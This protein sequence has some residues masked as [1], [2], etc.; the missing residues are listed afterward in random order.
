MTQKFRV[1]GTGCCLV[2]RLYS[3]V[4]FDSDDIAFLM[5]G[6]RG[7]GG[8]TPGQLVFREELEKYSKRDLQQIMQEITQGRQPDKINVGGPA[9]VAMIHAAQITQDAECTYHFYGYGGVDREGEFLQA[10]LQKTPLQLDHYQL[11]GVPTPSTVVLSDPEYN[12]GHGERM[13]INSIGTAWDFAPENLDEE[14]FTSDVVIFGGTALVPRIHDHL[15]E[16]LEKAKSKGCITVVNTVFDFR[17]EK[18]FPG[19]KWPMGKSD[20][21][22]GLTDLLIMDC[23]EALRLSGE[24]DI[25]SAMQFFRN[26]GT[27]TVIITNGSA[28]ILVYSSGSLFESLDEMEMPVSRVVIDEVKKGKAGD[29]TGCGD[30][31]AGGVIASMVN[32]IMAGYGKPDLAEASTWGIVSGGYTCFYLGGTYLEQNPGEK[33]RNLLPYYEQYINQIHG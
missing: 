17:N 6:K 28:N 16:L 13:F 9:I 12:K 2:D 14:F 11:C 1:S 25:S 31:F 8:L 24:K 23:E 29:T 18:A 20:E 21:S 15:T 22:Y 7:D 3:N 33:H 19:K 4:S 27:G 26:R 30:N 10:S 5:S 32:Q